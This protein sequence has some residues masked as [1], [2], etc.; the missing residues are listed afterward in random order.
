[1]WGGSGPIPTA[2]LFLVVVLFSSNFLISPAASV[3]SDLQGYSIAEHPFKS[4]DIFSSFGQY[5]QPV[6]VKRYHRY[7]TARER[8]DLRGM[9]FIPASATYKTYPY[10]DIFGFK[11]DTLFIRSPSSGKSKFYIE[12]NQAARVIVLASGR[13]MRR[14]FAKETVDGLS[15]AG[16]PSDWK[17]PFMVES[18]MATRRV[19]RVKRNETTFRPLLPRFALAFEVPLGQDLK[20]SLPD[21]RGLSA[22]GMALDSYTLLFGR[23]G[24]EDIVPFSL[25]PL[26]EPFLSPITGRIINPRND[27]PRPNEYCPEWLHDIYVTSSHTGATSD[28]PTFWRTWHGAIDHFYWCYFTHEHG[29]HPGPNYRPP[30]GYTAWKTPDESTKHGRQDESHE[31]FKVVSFVAADDDRRVSLTVHAHLSQPRRFTAR[32][33]TVIFA[34]SGGGRVQ[35]QLFMKSDFGAALGTLK[36][37]NRNIPIGPGQV[38]I[39]QEVGRTAGRRFN[40]V[41]IDPGYPDTVNKTFKTRR[42]PAN[43][44]RLNGL[45]EKWNG[46]ING[47]TREQRR[48]HFRVDFQNPPTGI[49]A[50]FDP[51]LTPLAGSGLKRAVKI[52]HF[53]FG[54]EHCA[55]GNQQLRNVTRGSFYTDSYMKEQKQGPGSWAVHQFIEPSFKMLVLPTG[56]LKQ[57]D[58]WDRYISYKPEIVAMPVNIDNAV[59]KTIN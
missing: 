59:D 35:A 48:P 11:L 9:I 29:A 31:G 6:I 38:Q 44:A 21:V 1:M 54:A 24:T 39:Y 20:L 13:K 15:T 49:R 28:E 8:T 56:R 26:P 33:H 22:N 42:L 10:K 12:L 32:H 36:S 41:N 23:P 18:D 37:T 46:N 55:P 17:A 57:A 3:A 53:E 43:P 58:V 7:D 47:C 45:Y 25:P 4:L 19:P 30:F 14:K 27:P 34:V 40:V 5:A 16:I 50:P 2:A 51:E 52:K